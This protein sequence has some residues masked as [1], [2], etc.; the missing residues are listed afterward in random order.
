MKCE[1]IAS[2]ERIAGLMVM[3]AGAMGYVMAYLMWVTR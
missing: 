3:V 2:D 1:L